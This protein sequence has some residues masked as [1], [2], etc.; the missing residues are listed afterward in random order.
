MAHW[1]TSMVFVDPGRIAAS[2]RSSPSM[3]PVNGRLRGSPRFR[4]W[5]SSDNSNAFPQSRMRQG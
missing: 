5:H 2:V 3:L 1:T 4:P